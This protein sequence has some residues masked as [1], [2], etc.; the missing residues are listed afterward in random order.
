MLARR[1]L[2]VVCISL[3]LVAFSN[4]ADDKE[5]EASGAFSIT[6]DNLVTPK[7]S[8][9]ERAMRWFLRSNKQGTLKERYDVADEQDE[10]SEL[11]T[12]RSSSDASPKEHWHQKLNHLKGEF[13]AIFPGT[14]W[15]GDGNI[16]DSET[17]LGKLRALDACCRAHDNCPEAIGAGK[18]YGRLLND[19]TF[20][21]SHCSCDREF[22]TCLK[23]SHSRT[24]KAIGKTY[25]NVLRPR[26]FALENPITECEKRGRAH[27]T[28]SRKCEKY[29][30][31]TSGEKKLQWFDNIDF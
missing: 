4:G 22:Y 10:P 31:D 11:A 19:G 26:C 9:M 20:T 24:A 13:R 8:K 14:K 15:C 18:S 27:R 3:G 12:G 23:N 21:K 25:F 30:L 1:G 2:F 7:L 29:R 28:R 6:A 16:A 17:D 5:L